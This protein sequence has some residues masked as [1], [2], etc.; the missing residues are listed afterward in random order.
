MPFKSSE[1]LV[2]HGVLDTHIYGE[3]KIHVKLKFQIHNIIKYGNKLPYSL[4]VVLS[5]SPNFHVTTKF[6]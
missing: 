1:S 5:A 3:Q 4:K 2:V 6:W